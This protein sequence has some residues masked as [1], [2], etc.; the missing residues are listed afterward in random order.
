M[1]GLTHDLRYAARALRRSPL[2]TLAVSLTLA[3]GIGANVAIFTVFHALM[4]RKPAVA[5]PD[6]LVVFTYSADA[7]EPAHFAVPD[8]AKYRDM[9]EVF[10]SVA[11][12]QIVRRAGAAVNANGAAVDVGSL[13]VAMVS[14]TF[15]S[16]IGVAALTGR[17]MTPEESAHGG[18]AVMVVSD[19]FAARAFGLPGNVIGRSVALLGTT[20][21]VI[22][23]L[24]RAFHGPWTGRDA[25]AWVPLAMQPA[26]M[27]ER[28]IC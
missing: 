3:L 2:F 21:T 16:T 1:T 8:F 4:L 24:P 13:D 22:G 28:P 18:Q 6:R 14:P 25:D 27:P 10:S 5:D 7:G 20:Y 15:F 9:P 26:V 23:V 11:T 12:F 19:A 17:T